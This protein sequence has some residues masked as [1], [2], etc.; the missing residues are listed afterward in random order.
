MLACASKFRLD[1]P[2][3]TYLYRTH[4]RS[5][6][7]LNMRILGLAGVLALLGSAASQSTLADAYFSTEIPIA[8]AGV[9]ANIGP[10]GAKSSGAEVCLPICINVCAFTR[11]LARHRDRQPEFYQP[12]LPIYLGSRLLTCIQSNCRSIHVGRRYLA[13]CSDR[14]FLHRRGCIAAGVQPEWNSHHRR[15]RRAK[16]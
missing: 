5:K 6:P 15:S 3:K 8:K 14:Q 13:T 11:V 2:I 9:L 7:T 4:T 1:F 16:I 12:Q 10:T